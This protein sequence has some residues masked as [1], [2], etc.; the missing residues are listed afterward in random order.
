[1][2]KIQYFFD[3][4]CCI[5]YNITASLS[6][7]FAFQNVV[8]LTTSINFNPC[9]FYNTPKFANLMP[10]FKAPDFSSGARHLFHLRFSTISDAPLLHPQWA[11][12]QANFYLSHNEQSSSQSAMF[13]YPTCQF[14]KPALYDDLMPQYT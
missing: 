8:F 1:M 7:I 11:Q 4:I 5:F 2:V 12:E 9:I 6:V 3:K 14:D 13:S 10:K